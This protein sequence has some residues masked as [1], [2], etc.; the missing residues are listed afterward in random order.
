M[1]EQSILMPAVPPAGHRARLLLQTGL[2]L[3][4]PLVIVVALIAIAA[5]L[6]I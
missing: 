1:H 5:T 6:V 3:I 2:F 4:L